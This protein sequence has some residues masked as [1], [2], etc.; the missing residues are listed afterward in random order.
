MSSH[1]EKR[2][3]LESCFHSNANVGMS[4]T[5]FRSLKG[6]QTPAAT[7]ECTTKKKR[8][9]CQTGRCF[10]FFLRGGGGG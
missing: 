8:K 4:Q 1:P 6:S 2:G 3:F 9:T 7:T 5:W 10:C